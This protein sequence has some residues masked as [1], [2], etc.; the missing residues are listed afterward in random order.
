MKQAES[1]LVAG[2]Q[3]TQRPGAEQQVFSPLLD[4][5]TSAGSG[6]DIR[7][8]G[9]FLESLIHTQSFAQLIEDLVK[10][11]VHQAE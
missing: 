2:A 9:P 7:D 4:D 1:H 8:I 6:Q 10:T 11:P 5:A 3:L